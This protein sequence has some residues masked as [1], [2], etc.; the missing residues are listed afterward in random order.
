MTYASKSTSFSGGV[1][2]AATDKRRPISKVQKTNTPLSVCNSAS[3]ELRSSVDTRS[4]TQGMEAFEEMVVAS[5]SKF[6]ATA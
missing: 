2:G 5:R 3:S 6:L 1:S 4:E